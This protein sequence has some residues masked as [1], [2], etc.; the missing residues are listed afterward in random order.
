MVKN[1]WKN[2]LNGNCSSQTQYV[3]WLP[4]FCNWISMNEKTIDTKF[5]WDDTFEL[6]L[7]LLMGT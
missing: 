5:K 6:S 3:E 1:E 7:Y 2:L 4:C